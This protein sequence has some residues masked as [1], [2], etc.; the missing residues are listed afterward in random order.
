MFLTTAAV[1]GII[2]T[3]GVTGF[4]SAQIASAAIP[5]ASRAP[6]SVHPCKAPSVSVNKGVNADGWYRVEAVVQS[7]PGGC[8]VEAAAS[9]Y[10]SESLYENVYGADVSTDGGKSFADCDYEYPI[11]VHGGY[12][13][14]AEDNVWVYHTYALTCTYPDC[15]SPG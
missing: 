8:P 2:M 7:D 3:L 1:A 12:R 6:L 13:Y 15:R 14:E 4:A 10:L 11:F 5:R 9:C